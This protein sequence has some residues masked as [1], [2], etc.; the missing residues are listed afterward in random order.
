ML[1]LEAALFSVV[2]RQISWSPHRPAI[3][4]SVSVA[5]KSHR[6]WQTLAEVLSSWLF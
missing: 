2:Y 1:M 6:A 5:G 3:S 4:C